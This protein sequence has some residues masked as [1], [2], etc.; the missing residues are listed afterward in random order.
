MRRLLMLALVVTACG[1]AID[2]GPERPEPPELP[3]GKIVRSVTIEEVKF[4]LYAGDCLSVAV[5]APGM[6]PAVE[7]FC[8]DGDWVTNATETCGWP[9]DQNDNDAH[10]CGITLPR[11]IY[12]RVTTPD[13]GWVCVGQI[14]EEGPITSVRFLE[15]DNDGYILQP[16]L[17]YESYHA[18][19]YTPGGVQYG[20]PP[21]DAPS[22]T[23]YDLCALRAP[24][25]AAGP[26]RD[27]LLRVHLAQSLRRSG[28]TLFLDTGTGPIGMS[29]SAIE[30]DE[31]A[32]FA[33]TVPASSPALRVIIEIEENQI[34]YTNSHDWPTA[35]LDAL[36]S[37]CDRPMEISVEIG[38]A[39]EAGQTEVELALANDPCGPDNQ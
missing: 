23:I 13:I 20:D 25:G 4:E 12:G 7:R 38:G 5:T 3:T 33:R 21:L 37:A 24:W 29:G 35:V 26:A 30:S 15:V 17:P 10:E 8:P 39:V 36:E 1:G 28:V 27:V 14:P 16:A 18:H 6:Q 34:G 9:T 19:L 22:T 2:R 32:V 11:V 31:P